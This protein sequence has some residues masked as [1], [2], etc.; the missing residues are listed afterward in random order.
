MGVLSDQ[1]LGRW[2]KLAFDALKELRYTRMNVYLGGELDGEFLSRF[3]IDGRNQN[4]K[5]TGLLKQ[6]T[7]IPFKFNI[8]IRGQF[9]SLLATARSFEDPRELIKRSQPLPVDAVPGAGVIQP[10]STGNTR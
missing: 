5:A 8:A 1:A 6:I 7:G 2:G 3:T 4:E 9:R 10:P